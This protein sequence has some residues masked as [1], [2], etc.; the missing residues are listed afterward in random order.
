MEI[1]ERNF[2]ATLAWD[3]VVKT[4]IKPLIWEDGWEGG[5]GGSGGNYPGAETEKGPATNSV[6]K[7]I[8]YIKIIIKNVPQGPRKTLVSY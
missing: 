8:L 4:G 2:T 6:Y 3:T 5:G 1:I 7:D